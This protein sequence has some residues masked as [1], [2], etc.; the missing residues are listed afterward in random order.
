MDRKRRFLEYFVVFV[1]GFLT[2]VN[3]PYYNNV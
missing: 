3:L 2:K 1:L